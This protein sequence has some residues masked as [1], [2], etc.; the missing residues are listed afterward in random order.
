MHAC[1]QKYCLW[2]GQKV[3]PSKSSIYF[4]KNT[5]RVKAISINAILGF[6]R[7][8]ETARH[9]G[10]PLF[11]GRN[12]TDNWQHILDSIQKRVTGWKSRVLSKAGR[13]TLIATI[14][15]AIPAYGMSTN[16]L[17]QKVCKAIDGHLRKFW[18]GTTEAG[19]PRIH[20]RA[21]DCI[22]KPKS[23]GGLGLRRTNDY[24]RAFLAK[25]GWLLISGSTALW[26]QVL[27]SKYV[28]IGTFMDST[29]KASDSPLW[30]AMVGV[31]DLIMK[32]ACILVGSGSTTNIWRDPW[33]PK[34]SS[35]RPT[36]ICEPGPGFAWVSDF[37][38][39]GQRWNL[40]KLRLAFHEEDVRRILHIPLSA[41]RQEDI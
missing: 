1:L 4:S 24:N 38:K 9:L 20:L 37:I 40:P 31:K 19:N 2:S 21:W 28:K 6:Q 12:K 3:N 32:G 15:Q 39:P 23:V 27:R 22:C 7:I 17:P 5:P 14:G 29:A 18:W 41:T 13:L 25:W 35:Y 34:H 16:K 8:K 36:P 33:V 30:K 26:A 11:M 10:L